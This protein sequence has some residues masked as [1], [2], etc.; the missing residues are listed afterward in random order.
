MED[1]DVF[2]RLNTR[3]QK[4]DIKPKC[5]CGCTFNGYASSTSSSGMKSLFYSTESGTLCNCINMRK[6]EAV[7]VIE[8][9]HRR[10]DRDVKSE[11]HTRDDLVWAKG[12]H[13]GYVNLFKTLVSS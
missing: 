3:L 6:A 2:S 5:I 11:R 7:S 10:P 9:V 12:S 1:Q 13:A 4:R 8:I